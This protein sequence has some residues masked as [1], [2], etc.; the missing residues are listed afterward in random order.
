M[1]R[2]FTKKRRALFLEKLQ[3]TGNVSAAAAEVKVHRSHVYDLRANDEAFR[4]A[5]EDAETAWLDAC[6]NEEARR[7]VVGDTRLRRVVR[8]KLDAQGKVLE[9][10]VEE[11]T[12]NVKSDRLL[13][14]M[15]DRRHPEYRSAAARRELTGE[16]G[17][18]IKIER[19]EFVVVDPPKATDAGGGAS[20]SSA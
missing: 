18:P 5:W 2:A 13:A 4:R 19:V 12:V 14:H 7:A 10:T 20:S 17:A 8:E 6:A 16:K 15:L 3:R 1:A 11:E 9:R